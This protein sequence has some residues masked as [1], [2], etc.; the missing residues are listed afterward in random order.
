MAWICKARELCLL[1]CGAQKIHGVSVIYFNQICNGVGQLNQIMFWGFH[2]QK[3]GFWSSLR[4]YFTATIILKSKKHGSFQ[5]WILLHVFSVKVN[6]THH[7]D[8]CVEMTN[9]VNN[10]SR[11]EIKTT[12]FSIQF[13]FFLRENYMVGMQRDFFSIINM[14]CT[15]CFEC[16]AVV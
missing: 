16:N 6:S 13:L 9:G 12:I 7:H 14:L 10:N 1:L 8:V 3:P 2:S 5:F 4:R 15:H 11:G